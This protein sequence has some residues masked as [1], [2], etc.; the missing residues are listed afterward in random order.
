[1]SSSK[2]LRAALETLQST[3]GISNRII[4]AV[5]AQMAKS[6]NSTAL[7]TR[8]PVLVATSVNGPTGFLEGVDIE[9]EEEDECKTTLSSRPVSQELSRSYRVKCAQS[10]IT[11]NLPT[12]GCHA[13][14][15]ALSIKGANMITLASSSDTASLLL[16]CPPTNDSEDI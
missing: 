6:K 12:F 15:A 9:N 4:N 5:E 1:M 14:I 11:P 2:S 7:L 3:K 10:E 16:L 8:L 13:S